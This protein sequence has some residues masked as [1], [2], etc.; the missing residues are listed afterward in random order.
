VTLVPQSADAHYQLGIASLLAGDR[1]S[2]ERELRRVLE[3]E[4]RHLRAMNDLAVLLRGEKRDAEAAAL[5][6]QV[7]AID[8]QQETARRNLAALERQSDGN[9]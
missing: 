4:P 5:L 2:A 1:E 3:L 9:R 8:P 6:R 7:L